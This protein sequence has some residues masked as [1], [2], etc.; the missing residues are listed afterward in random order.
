MARGNIAHLQLPFVSLLYKLQQLLQSDIPGSKDIPQFL[1]VG[2]LKRQTL[3]Q[4]VGTHEH[5]VV[6]LASFEQVTHCVRAGAHPVVDDG[7]L[8]QLRQ[9]GVLLHIGSLDENTVGKI[10]GVVRGVGVADIELAAFALEAVG[11]ND[12]IASDRSAG[13]KRNA[14][15]GEINGVHM[16]AEN[17]YIALVSAVPPRKSTSN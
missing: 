15:G 16:S 14:W 11:G 9:T 4:I 10:A 3:R 5:D 7:H 13:G 6:Q 1:K 17:N 12:K 8:R 2:I